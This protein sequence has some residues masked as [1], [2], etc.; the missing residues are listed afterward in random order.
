MKYLLLMNGKYLVRNNKMAFIIFYKHFLDKPAFLGYSDIGKL[1]ARYIYLIIELL[2][3]IIYCRSIAEL[4]FD[5]T[6][7]DLDFLILRKGKGESRS[8]VYLTKNFEGIYKIIKVYQNEKEADKEIGFIEKYNCKSK[9][10]TFPGY[11]RLNELTIEYDF[12]NE[13]NLWVAIKL[14]YI[15]GKQ[16]E[17]LYLRITEALD[18]MYGNKQENLIHGDLFPVNIYQKENTFAIIDF[19]DSHFHEIRYDYY[20]LLT[21]MVNAYYGKIKWDIIEEKF[22]KREITKFCNHYKLIKSKKYSY[23]YS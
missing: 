6:D 21:T 15:K 4:V 8:E 5:T 19:S 9:E 7:C 13:M 14:G 20:Y 1:S 2:I 16:L 18:V 11:K 23:D 22:S 12:I 10:I 3:K 17:E